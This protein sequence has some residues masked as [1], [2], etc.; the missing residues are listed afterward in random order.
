[1]PNLK[2]R[3]VS[4]FKWLVINNILQKMLSIGTFAV[5]ARILEPSTF[6]IFA[7]AFVAIDGV[8]IF[9]TFGLDGGIIQKKDCP[10]EANHTAFFLIQA[11]SVSLFLL[12]FVLTP[13]VAD[14]F[15]YTGLKSI[16][17]AL[18]IVFVLG[19]LG[20]VPSAL[21]T[22]SLRF[23]L[24]STIDLIGAAVNSLFAILFAYLSPTVWSLVGAYLIKQSVITGLAWH[25]SGY[26]L[27]WH[28]DKK[29]AAE[30][31]SFGKFLIG[32][33]VLWYLGSNLNHLVVGK[34][35]GAAALGYY[36][37]AVNATNFIN[38]QFTHI[39]SRVMFPAYSAI[40][41][42]LETLKRA[43]LKTI[44]FISM[45]SLPFSVVLICLADEFVLTLYGEKWLSIVPLIRW[46]GFGQ[47]AA[48]ILIASGSLFRGSGRPDYDF[49]INLFQLCIQVPLAIFFTKIGGLVG[50]A[51]AGLVCLAVMGPINLYLV[52][53]ITQVKFR[54]FM[55]QLLPAASCS[56]IMLI[57]ILL[58][59]NLFRTHS[60][61]SLPPLSH[62]MVFG[63]LAAAGIL[64]Y[65]I[66]FFFIDRP[67]TLE[68][69]RLLF[70]FKFER[71]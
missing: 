63:L 68:V 42:D 41:D 30:L 11:I 46:L 10:E 65:A 40:Q 47:I 33:S 14:F 16:L 26:Q 22:R 60:L 31:F 54:E 69:R 7:M 44:K 71:A 55:A 12:F 5:L 2:E 19:G 25:F 32:L 1:M 57:A 28:F 38:N 66:S 48:P 23:R 61:I 4:G 35:L 13:L 27:R 52:R 45:L 21:L 3:T 53:K 56:L 39:I 58:L 50:A 24:I 70:K 34:L 15:N 18:G 67:A 49:R 29:I 37:M 62:F 8:G 36:A 9:K 17:R 20:R 51:A 64:A 43:Y 6:G 59:K